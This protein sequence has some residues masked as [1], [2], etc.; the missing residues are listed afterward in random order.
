MGLPRVLKG[1]L[2]SIT[3]VRL[4]CSPQPVLIGQN[5]FPVILSFVKCNHRAL[6]SEMMSDI[7]IS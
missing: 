4:A 1:F 3:D 5:M 7:K 6:F 2:Y